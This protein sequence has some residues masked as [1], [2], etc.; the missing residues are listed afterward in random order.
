MKRVHL[1]LILFNVPYVLDINDCDPNPCQNGGT[2]ADGVN[3]YSCSCLGGYTG[4]NC[5]IGTSESTLKIQIY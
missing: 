5:S 3:N 4:N 1:L 2:C